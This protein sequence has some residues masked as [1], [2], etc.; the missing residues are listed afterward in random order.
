MR[1]PSRYD[2]GLI[3]RL[4]PSRSLRSLYQGVGRE[5]GRNRRRDLGDVVVV[6]G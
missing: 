5:D 4:R 1:R 3:D 2:F 6:P